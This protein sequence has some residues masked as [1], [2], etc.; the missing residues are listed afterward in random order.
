MRGRESGMP[1][2]E[3]WE[4]FFDSSGVLSIMGLSS[5]TRD[6]AEFGCGYGTFTIPAAMI[7]KGT[8]YAIDIDKEMTALTDQEA[9]RNNL[10]NVKTL[11][12]DFAAEGTGLDAGSVDYVM[13]FNILHIEHPEIMLK[14][15][16]RI[17]KPKGKLGIIHWNYDPSTPRGP[18]I[19]I[20]PKPED[21]IIWAK[22]VGFTDSKIHDLKPYHYGIVLIKK[23]ADK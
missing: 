18:S 15:A 12:R 13:L 9:K 19:D 6:V 4:G 10:Y 20:R 16:S 2:K 22:Q 8:V 5:D 3:A 11:L 14:E 7:V 17:L 1:G 21:C 23:E